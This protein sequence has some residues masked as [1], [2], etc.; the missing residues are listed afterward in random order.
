[1]A[2]YNEAVIDPDTNELVK[3]G[4]FSVL[5]LDLTEAVIYEYDLEGVE[6]YTILPQPVST[7]SS[8]VL[9]FW[10][11]PG[12]Y[13]LSRGGDPELIEL[14]GQYINAEP[15]GSIPLTRDS[16]DFQP[17]GLLGTTFY[18]SRTPQTPLGGNTTLE[19]FQSPGSYI[20]TGSTDITLTFPA[21]SAPNGQWVLYQ[22]GT[23]KITVAVT[24]PATRSNFS[25]H[26]KT[27]GPKAV[28]LVT[29]VGTDPETPEYLLSGNTAA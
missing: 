9:R 2:F 21:L 24:S 29:N 26:T 15:E 23:G 19:N 8:G 5:N 4:A 13:Y 27:A 20:Y 28:V 25:S 12:Y 17:N 3:D 16:D 11:E 6:G 22:L 10:G 7:N 18:N 1:M 14:V